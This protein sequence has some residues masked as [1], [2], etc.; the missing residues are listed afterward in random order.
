M[1]LTQPDVGQGRSGRGDLSEHLNPPRFG[2]H[3][4]DSG[5][6][7]IRQSIIFRSFI[8]VRVRH[9]LRLLRDYSKFPKL[10]ELP[11]ET[12]VCVDAIRKTCFADLDCA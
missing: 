5:H 1:G 9:E 2:Q 4:T 7:T 12:F 10:R 8:F 3:P 11:S 6:L